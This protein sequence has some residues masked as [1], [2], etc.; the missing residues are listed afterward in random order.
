M[1][2]RGDYKSH[3][4]RFTPCESK[5]Q[6]TRELITLMSWAV[7]FMAVILPLLRVMDLVDLDPKQ[8]E[9]PLPQGRDS[10][11]YA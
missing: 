10:I 8:I 2:C 11:H 1:P 9:S 6:M 7:V 3:P 5:G 4:Y